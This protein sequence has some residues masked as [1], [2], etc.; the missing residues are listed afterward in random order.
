MRHKGDGKSSL[1]LMELHHKELDLDPMEPHHKEGDRSTLIWR[2]F[3]Y[4]KLPIQS[5]FNL[6]WL[7]F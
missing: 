7:F 2:Y 5:V 6:I 3:W 1:D 4:S